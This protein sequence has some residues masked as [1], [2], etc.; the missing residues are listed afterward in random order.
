MKLQLDTTNKSIKLES[1]ILL[2]ELVGV[3]ERLLPRGEWKTFTLQTNVTINNWSNPIIIGE[4]PTQTYPAHPTYP[5]IVWCGSGSNDVSGISAS[6]SLNA[7][8]YNVEC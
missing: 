8:T 5:W 3:L 6:Y 1:D 4:Y 7:G 2:S